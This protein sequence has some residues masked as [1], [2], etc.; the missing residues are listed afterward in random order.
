VGDICRRAGVAKTALYWHFQSKEGLLAA[1]VEAVGSGWIEELEKRCYLTGDPTERLNGL[2]DGLRALVRDE[3]QLLRLPLFLQLEQGAASEPTR[4]AV[5]ALYR[6]AEQAIVRG[7]EDSF[8]TRAI[9]DLDLVAHT[10]LS[11]LQGAVT[12]SAWIGDDAELDRLFDEL[13]RTVVLALWARLPAG[14]RAELEA[15]LAARAR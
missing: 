4:A 14:A 2:I 3:P 11:L 15:D 5:G 6:R 10:I 7:I 8:G 13:R 12:R 1:V 9:P